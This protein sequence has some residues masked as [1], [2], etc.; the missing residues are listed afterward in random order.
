MKK[1]IKVMAAIMLVA[2]MVFSI[3]SCGGTDISKL[4]GDWTLSSIDGKSP[5][6]KAGELGL[7]SYGLLNNYTLSGNTLTVSNYDPNSGNVVERLQFTVEAAGNGF[8]ATD[9]NGGKT[10]FVYDSSADTLSYSAVGTSGAAESYVLKRGAT[11]ILAAVQAA[12]GASE[13]GEEA[14]EG[15]EAYSEEGGEEY[16]E[17]YAAE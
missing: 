7:P 17:E 13:G 1:T 14:A 15:G 9:S 3:A 4:N 5:A 6:D 12:S 8:T 2:A 11:D 16:S 10:S